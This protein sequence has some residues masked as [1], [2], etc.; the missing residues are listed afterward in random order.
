MKVYPLY[1]NGQWVTTKK[2]IRVV[3]PATAERDIKMV[4]ELMRHY[5]HNLMGIYAE[6]TGAGDIAVGDQIVLS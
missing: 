5:G 4:A 6:V 2:T 1:L 3:N